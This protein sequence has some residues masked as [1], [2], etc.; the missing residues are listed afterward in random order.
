MTVR[1]TPEQPRR[2]WPVVAAREVEVKLRDRN[3]LI[4]SAVLLVLL[5][6]SLAFQMFVSHQANQV[7]VAVTGGDAGSLVAAANDQADASDQTLELHSHTYDSPA[8]ARAAVDS[9]DVDIALVG[10][11]GSWSLV[12][13]DSRNQTADAALSQQVAQSALTQ[14]A[15]RVGV[16]LDELTQGAQLPYQLLVPASER[17]PSARVISTVFGLLFYIATLVFGTAIANSVVEEKQNR[18]VEILA[19]AIPVRQLL[20][21]KVVGNTVLALGQVLLLAMLGVVGLQVTGQGDFL[22]QVLAGSGWFIAYFLVGFAALACMWA[23]VGSLASRA[24][25][26]QSTSPPMTVLVL[27]VFFAGILASGTLAHVLAYVPLFSTIA[28]PTLV[29]TGDASWVEAVAG[30]ATTVVGAALIIRLAERM[31]LG[32]LMQTGRRMRVREVLR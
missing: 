11:P 29:I 7:D 26:I 22:H 25:D 10:Q 9:G 18:V 16:G 3:F 28:M 15:A 8:A 1:T 21:G 6:C 5:V 20:I 19:A 27:G 2:V 13:K 23:V 12:G 31:Y 17:H 30:L 24:E 14:N 4:A 32:S